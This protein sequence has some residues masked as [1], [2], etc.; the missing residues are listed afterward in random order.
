MA[1]SN[2]SVL[3]KE[4]KANHWHPAYSLFLFG[5]SAEMRFFIFF[6][7]ANHHCKSG[8]RD[9]PSLMAYDLK[10][11]TQTLINEL[12]EIESFA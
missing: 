12:V 8:H 2:A 7:Q 4:R 11:R 5:E 10:D 1:Q 3:T 6:H 9:I